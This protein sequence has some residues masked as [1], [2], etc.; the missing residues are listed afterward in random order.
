VTITFDNQPAPLLYVSSTQINVQVPFEIKTR[1]ST[2]MQLSFNGS[3][4]GTRLFA[5][6]PENPGMFVASK[7]AG[8]TCGDETAGPSLLAFAINDDGTLNSCANPAKAGSLVSLFVNGIGTSGGN[9]A[10][11][12]LNGLDPGFVSG[13]AEVS[14]GNYSAEVDSIN[15]Q[16]GAISGVAQLNMRIPETISTLTPESPISLT[17]TLNNLPA[18]PLAAGTSP[19]SNGTSIPLT[20]FA[21]P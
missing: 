17:V 8:F 10:T 12:A 7:V 19:V 1:A 21:K 14:I 16:A 6:A 20:I 3:V 15:N 13:T 4:P 5:V 9:L 11:G 18:G 2:V